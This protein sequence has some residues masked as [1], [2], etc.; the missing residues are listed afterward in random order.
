[1]RGRQQRD[2]AFTRHLFERGEKLGI[3]LYVEGR[4]VP[5]EP[6]NLKAW[7]TLGVDVPM[8]VLSMAQH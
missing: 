4:V 1:M 8:T 5:R 6:P 3:R 7:E 2:G